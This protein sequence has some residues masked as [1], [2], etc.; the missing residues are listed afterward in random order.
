MNWLRDWP[1]RQ[2]LTLVI[3][4][5][6]GA[7]LLMACGLLGMYQVYE[8][9]NATARD[10]TVLADVLAKNT[11]AALAFQDESAAQQT[12]RALQ[13]EPYV[14]AAC[15]YDDKGEPFAQYT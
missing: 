10:S 3:M 15:V 9:G 2:K 5:T 8:F 7:V 4:I 14:T 1:I 13:V 11:Q 12:L 6:C